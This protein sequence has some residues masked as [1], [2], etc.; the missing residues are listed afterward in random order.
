MDMD[1][2]SPAHD[3]TIHSM[4]QSGDCRLAVEVSRVE[5]PTIEVKQKRNFAAV[6]AV[7][8]LP[9]FSSALSQAQ[10]EALSEEICRSGFGW[11]VVL[12]SI[13][14]DGSRAARMGRLKSR[15][16]AADRSPLQLHTAVSANVHA[17]FPASPLCF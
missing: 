12:A 2:I 7:W 17:N 14:A 3:H 13:L 5:A 6:T 1:R 4:P 8:P 16:L 10:L 9:S 15:C 11:F